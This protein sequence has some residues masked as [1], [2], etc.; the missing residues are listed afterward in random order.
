M[1][2]RAESPGV[3]KVLPMATGATGLEPAFDT[4]LVRGL[5]PSMTLIRPAICGHAFDIGCDVTA[6]NNE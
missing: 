4:G 3:G 5:R 6:S 1:G 2:R